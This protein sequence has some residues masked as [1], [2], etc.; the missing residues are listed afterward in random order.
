M[1]LRIL[2]PFPRGDPPHS[3]SEPYL[4]DVPDPAVRFIRPLL[5]TKYYGV[6]VGDAFMDDGRV[7]RFRVQSRDPLRLAT[8]TKAWSFKNNASS[9]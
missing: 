7:L 5:A 6:T 9:A 3:L 2:P 4:E 1:R 8:E